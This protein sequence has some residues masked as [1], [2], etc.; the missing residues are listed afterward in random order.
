MQ[1]HGID[2][3]KATGLGSGRMQ[4][5]RA[6]SD[7]WMTLLKIVNLGSLSLQARFEPGTAG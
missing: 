7:T 2:N 1:G 4:D 5:R 6:H 3:R